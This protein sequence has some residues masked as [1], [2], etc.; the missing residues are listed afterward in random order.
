MPAEHVGDIALES[1]VPLRPAIPESHPA[2]LATIAALMGLQPPRLDSACVLEIGCGDGGNLIPLATAMPKASF[3]GEDR[4]A[5]TIEVCQE[6]ANELGLENLRFRDSANSETA[7]R[8][9]GDTFDYII[10]GEDLAG[11]SDSALDACLAACQSRLRP[12]GLIYVSYAALPGSTMSGVVAE[13]ARF[14]ARKEAEPEAKEERVRSVLRLISDELPSQRASYTRLFREEADRVLDLEASCDDAMSRLE[15]FQPRFYHEVEAAANR[16]GLRQLADARL[17]S[18]LCTQ[19]SELRHV[20]EFASDDP[21]E[22]EQFLDFL[23]NRK[24]RRAVLTHSGAERRDEPRLEGV[25]RL[26]ARAAALPTHDD[27]DVATPSPTLYVSTRKNKT[28][29]VTFPYLKAVLA[30]LAEAWPRSL[31]TSQV[32]GRARERLSARS[33]LVPEQGSDAWASLII[34]ATAAGLTELFIWEPSVGS[35][36]CEHPRASDLARL[37]AR[38][39]R[40][41]TNLRHQT[42]HLDADE[43]ALIQ[44]LDGTSHRD[45]LSERLG[46][47]VGNGHLPGADG[48]GEII[49]QMLASLAANSLVMENSR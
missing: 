25:E 48:R 5:R 39:D 35:E 45:E 43:R 33:L 13:L 11:Y 49:D 27:L 16:N 14:V 2:H 41:I 42:V 18:W 31:P 40:P 38:A 26:L 37:Q 28:H 36:R 46:H 1:R 21:V 10:I 44:C 8:K 32:I 24:H 4:H 29:V 23:R 19:P 3:V 17:G 7:H 47:L 30:V 12:N 6:I 20:L 15:H 22:R 9:R 34:Q